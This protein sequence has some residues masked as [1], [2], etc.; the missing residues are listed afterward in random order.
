MTFCGHIS[1]MGG[2]GAG[3][4]QTFLE[5]TTF[6]LESASGGTLLLATT[7]FERVKTTWS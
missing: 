2:P 3:R 6:Q 7:T 4:P 1:K 5:T